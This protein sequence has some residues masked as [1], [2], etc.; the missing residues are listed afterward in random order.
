MT[1][2]TRH[3][4]VQDLPAYREI[5]E[6]FFPTTDWNRGM[7]RLRGMLAKWPQGIFAVF[8]EDAIVGYITLWPLQPSVVPGLEAGTV[9]DEAIDS[10]SLASEPL[11]RH[12]YWL[13]SA[14]A[15]R[16]QAVPERRAIIQLLLRY[17]HDVVRDNA[18]C[19]VYAHTL[20]ADGVRFCTRTG[21]RFIFPSTKILC[22]YP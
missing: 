10:N 17:F 6:H 18:P 21:F 1:L 15:V 20:T 16:P 12:P 19:R 2:H 5:G 9:K 13:M 7:E 4:A 22:V 3:L 11:E 8:D 14:V